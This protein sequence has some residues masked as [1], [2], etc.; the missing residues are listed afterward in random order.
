[1]EVHNIQLGEDAECDKQVM[2]V[3]DFQLGEDVMSIMRM[4]I[5]LMKCLEATKDSLMSK[6]RS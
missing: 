3:H 1:M 4:M 6:R 2:M 5:T